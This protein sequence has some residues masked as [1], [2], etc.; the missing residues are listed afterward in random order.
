MMWI[1]I[2]I[3]KYSKIKI[4]EKLYF[5]SKNID[6]ENY[7]NKI[8]LFL[9]YTFFIKFNNYSKNFKILHFLMEFIN[10]L[11]N[12]IYNFSKLQFF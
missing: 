5:T 7:N 1:L 9:M 6:I 2:K 4:C 3:I 11:C 12:R 10:I 8:S